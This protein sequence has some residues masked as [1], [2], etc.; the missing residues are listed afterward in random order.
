[1]KQ[2]YGTDL[3]HFFEF[4]SKFYHTATAFNISPESDG[5]K[6]YYDAAY[7]QNTTQHIL[8]LFVVGKPAS[9][10]I[11]RSGDELKNFILNELDEIYNNQASMSYVKHIVQNWNNEPYI[12]AAYLT[13]HEDWRRVRR[14]SESVADKLYFAGGAYTDGEDWVS[15]HTAAQSAKEAVAE[16]VG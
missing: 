15:V 4:S 13:D 6:L 1:M 11:N 8:G 3:K 16:L 2:P 9:D 12:K 5:Q 10:Y 14:L 7:G